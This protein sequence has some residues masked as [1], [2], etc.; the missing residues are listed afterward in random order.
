MDTEL[1]S[2]PERFSPNVILRPLYQE[3]I[4]PNLSYTGGPAEVAYWLQLKGVF[5]EAGV[6]FPIL[7]PRNFALVVNRATAKK[8]VKLGLSDQ[9]LFRS[10]Q[11]LKVAY[12]NKAGAGFAID[13]E[14]KTFE[15]ITES[16]S[17]KAF[18]IDPSLKS[19]IGAEMA[20]A[21]KSLDNIE[22]RLKKTEEN[23]HETDLSQLEKLKDR[24]FP[25]RIP[26]ER[27][28]NFLNYYINDP[29][30]IESLISA[31]DPFDMQ[32]YLLKPQ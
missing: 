8:Q 2:N 28:E 27:V 13:S 5:D 26:Q 11:E 15:K 31:F 1:E 10:F 23:K 29:G 21:A 7:V 30:F 17:A 20:K 9:D 4:L 12:L 18:E 24:L 16:L 19:W 6:P 25:N 22:K 32:M 3:V 14:R